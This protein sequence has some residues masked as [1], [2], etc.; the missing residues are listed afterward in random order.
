VQIM[1]YVLL[2]EGW[3]DGD[4][5]RHEA[6]DTV[7]VDA[8]TLAVLQARGVAPDPDGDGG[9]DSWAGPTGGDREGTDSWAGPTSDDDAS[10]DSWAGP[11]DDDAST[12]SW[13]GPT[14]G[15][16]TESWAGPTRSGDS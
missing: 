15:E 7:D 1:V 2:R 8:A 10:T 11:T 9:T 3:T 12:D 4:G 16:G 13:A 6:G 14:D 5:T